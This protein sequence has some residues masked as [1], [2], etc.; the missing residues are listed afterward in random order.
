[1]AMKQR[2]P[3][4]GAPPFR[5]SIEEDAMR[6]DPDAPYG[7]LLL[8]DNEGQRLV[9]QTDTKPSW[10]RDS[11]VAVK[12]YDDSGYVNQQDRPIRSTFQMAADMTP[13][14]YRPENGTPYTNTGAPWHQGQLPAVPYGDLLVS[15]SPLDETT[16]D[17]IIPDAPEMASS[18]PMPHPRGINTPPAPMENPIVRAGRERAESVNDPYLDYAPEVPIR[19]ERKLFQLEGEPEIDP[20]RLSP[21]PVIDTRELPTAPP[22]ENP[23]RRYQRELDEL[24][25]PERG[26]VSKWAKLAAVAL[27]AGQGYYNAANPNARPIDASEAVQNLTFGRKYLDA[28]GEY[29][30]KRKDIGERIKLAGD[31]DNIESNIAYR[32]EMTASRKAANDERI[33]QDNLSKEAKEAELLNRRRAILVSLEDKGETRIPIDAPL[34]PGMVEGGHDP[35]FEMGADGKPAYRRVRNPNHGLMETT[36]EMRKDNPGL[37][38]HVD[39]SVFNTLITTGAR[40]DPAEQ[41]NINHW[42]ATAADPKATLEQKAIAEAK[43]KKYAATQQAVRVSVNA[44][45]PNLAPLKPVERGS[46]EYSVARDMASGDLTFSQFTKLFSRSTDANKRLAIYDA[47]REINR[48]FNPAAFEAGYGFAKSPKVRAQIASLNNVDKGVDDLLKFSDKAERS[49]FTILNKAILPGGVAF[50]NKNFTNFRTAQLAFAD[51]L[52]G[53]LGYGTATDM[54]KQMS[55]DLT[56]PNFS[57]ESFKAA[58]NDVVVP[59]IARKRSSLTEQMG[60]YGNSLVTTENGGNAG[61]GRG[62]GGLPKVTT[63][64]E[65]AAVRSGQKFQDENGNVRTKK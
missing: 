45:N 58:I 61:P 35:L 16:N 41:E 9:E 31:A 32:A 5:D 18:A 47:A 24:K 10:N 8:G 7:K 49:G 48:S 53:A 29:Q 51:E 1:M 33:R 3:R 40:R 6:D 43:I 4:F 55:L 46:K 15:S 20:A 57:P 34:P 54:A 11:I 14:V 17:P 21:P 36:P 39:R 64:A 38:T 22:P 37:P 50:G 25:A 56:N 2:F 12:D 19:G 26:P 60:P 62:G 27:G 65:Y 13:S 42:V 63:P 44:A 23:V 52:S 30:R 59:F 28:M